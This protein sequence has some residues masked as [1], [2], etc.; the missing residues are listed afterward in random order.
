V[1]DASDPPRRNADTY[2]AAAWL[3]DRNI[4]NG[5]GNNV[6]FVVDNEP[7]TYLELQR[8]VW[9]AQHALAE[10]G[11]RRGERRAMVVNDELAFPLSVGATAI[12]NPKRPT[13]PD[14]LRLVAEQKPTLFFAAPGLSPRSLI[15]TLWPT[16]S[17]RC[18]PP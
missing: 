6:T 8:Q 1:P 18:A 3:I 5:N 16:R 2:N 7:T 13:P 12:L 15:A 4:E 14:V 10:L 17:P 11:V 9:R